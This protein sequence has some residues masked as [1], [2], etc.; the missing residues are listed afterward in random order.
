MFSMRRKNNLFYFFNK[1]LNILLINHV[2]QL[3][4]SMFNLKLDINEKSMNHDHVK[5]L[6]QN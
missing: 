1:S 2:I 5:L 6:N 3:K 4:A